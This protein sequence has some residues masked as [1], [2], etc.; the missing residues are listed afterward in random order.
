MRRCTQA[1]SIDPE[2]STTPLASSSH[3]PHLHRNPQLDNSLCRRSRN[4]TWN[5][6]VVQVRRKGKKK[7]SSYFHFPPR[8]NETFRIIAV[9]NPQLCWTIYKVSW[10][11]TG[12]FCVGDLRLTYWWNATKKENSYFARSRHLSI[13]NSWHWWLAIALHRVQ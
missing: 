7:S 3:L 1:V 6:C 12:G 13:L 10:V 5:C 9:Y 8:Y 4:G 2:I 11:Y